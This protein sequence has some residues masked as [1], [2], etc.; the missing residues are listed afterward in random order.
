MGIIQKQSINGL[1]LSYA[2]VILGFITTGYLMP[3]YLLPE[4]IGLLRV[5]VSYSTL[6]AQFSGLGF[7]IVAVKM[8]PYFRDQQSKHHGFMGL[9]LLISII[10]FIITMF[11]FHIYRTYFMDD[12]FLKSPLLEKYFF[13]TIPLTVF[14]LLYNIADTFYRSIFNA[15][16]GVTQKE[17]VQKLFILLG[18]TVFITH[19]VSFEQLVLLYILAFAVPPIVLFYSLWKENQIKLIPDFK[20]ITKKIRKEMTSIAFYGMLSSFSGILVIN[21]DVLMIERYLNLTDAGIYTITFF[22]GALILVP[23]RPLTRIS[24]IVVAESFK[25]K[26]MTNIKFIYQ[27]SHITLTVLGIWAFLGLAINMD[28]IFKIIGENYRPGYYVI[29]IIALSNVFEMTTGTVNQVIFNSNIYKY[30]SYLIGAFAILLIITNIILIPIYGILG[31][32]I[33]TFASKLIYHS[34]K[35]IVVKLKLGL[36]LFNSK[37]IYPFLFGILA[38]FLQRFIP[39]FE[40]YIIDL[41]I[42]SLFVSVAYLT[43]IIWLQVSSDINQWIGQLILTLKRPEK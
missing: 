23:S 37:S 33:A 36:S 35:I 39:S 31:A 7:A 4:E 42:R 27:K 6:L 30:S 15:I 41:I 3:K 25:L 2:G 1:I 28:T 40:N 26:D 12:N 22:F 18:L 11:F 19:Y 34:A 38:F 43:P 16:K 29:L 13:W 32:A 21:I 24:S 20:F 8:F 9:F 17:I 10:G 5:I 14:L